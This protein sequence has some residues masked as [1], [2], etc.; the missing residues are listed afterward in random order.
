[1]GKKKNA[2]R[3]LVWK[4]ED[5]RQAENLRSKWEDNINYIK[6]IGMG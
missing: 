2:Q 5:K 6:K 1:V 4:A 3:S